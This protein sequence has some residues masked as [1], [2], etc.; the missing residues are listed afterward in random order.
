M[1]PPAPFSC[2]ICSEPSS[3]ICVYCTKDACDN[4]LC[5]RCHRCSDCCVCE[6]PLEETRPAVNQATD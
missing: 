1:N 3:R 5:A 2:H 6:I 4:H